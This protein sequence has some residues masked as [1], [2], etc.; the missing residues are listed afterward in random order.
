M[1]PADRPE[2]QASF[3]F[4][5][6]RIRQAA[7]LLLGDQARQ[8]MHLRIGRQLLREASDE[9]LLDERIY[10]IVDQLDRGLPLV[11]AA[12]ERL[13]LSWLHLR[14]AR[15]ARGASAHL[16]ALEYLKVARALLP[17]D[18]WET[19]RR[20]TFVLHREAIQ[21]AGH[22]GELDLADDLFRHALAH[23]E[24][25]AERA[26]LYS[27]RMYA[28]IAQAAREEAFRWGVEGVRLFGIELPSA[29]PEGAIAR[30]VAAI[31]ARLRGRTPAELLEAPRME[32]PE[33]LA[34]MDLLCALLDATYF[35]RPD[36]FP[37][38]AARMVEP[39]SSTATRSPPPMGT[40]PIR[41]CSGE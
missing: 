33:T 38:V 2:T 41:C 9:P 31:Q 14:A 23:A 39:R 10:A 18:A 27:V 29:D 28:S 40:W 17:D 3:R 16:P 1:E 20:D 21:A 26:D 37:F 13:R 8:A 11:T 15:K 32:A 36:L 35:H 30:E 6:D 5:H 4:A 34:C 7:Y 25:L 24:S 22:A 19:H 12:E